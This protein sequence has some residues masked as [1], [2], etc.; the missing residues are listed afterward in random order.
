MFRLNER[1]GNLV[2][3]KVGFVPRVLE[4]DASYLAVGL[5]LL[6]HKKLYPHKTKVLWQ[7]ICRPNSRQTT[8]LHNSDSYES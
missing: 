1:R 2:Y 6:D 4:P 7:I 3:E 8:K 5:V